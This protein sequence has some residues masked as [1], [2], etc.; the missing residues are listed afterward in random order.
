VIG[1]DVVEVAPI[2]NQ[3]VSATVAAKII[4]EMLCQLEKSR[5][6]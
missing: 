4:F 6:P 2:Y 5:K 3:D 1:F